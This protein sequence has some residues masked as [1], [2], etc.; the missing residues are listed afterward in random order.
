MEDQAKVKKVE[1]TTEEKE[2]FVIMPE[3]QALE[4][5]QKWQERGAE[6]SMSDYAPSNRDIRATEYRRRADHLAIEAIRK[7][8]INSNDETWLNYLAVI[9]EIRTQYPDA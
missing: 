8:M 1:I 7:G 9:N 5:S 3:E 2:F 4:F 6:I